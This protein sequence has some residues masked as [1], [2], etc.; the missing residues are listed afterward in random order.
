M[1]VTVSARGNPVVELR[2]EKLTHPVYNASDGILSDVRVLEC[3]RVVVG[4]KEVKRSSTRRVLEKVT[5]VFPRA[6]VHSH[7]ATRAR[8]R[9][10]TAGVVSGRRNVPLAM[11]VNARE[12]KFRCTRNSN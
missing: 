7:P 11:H 12:T 9:Q 3:L 5:S 4:W 2:V 1:P 6:M 8:C 10:E